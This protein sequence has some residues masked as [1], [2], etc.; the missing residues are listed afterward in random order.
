MSTEGAPAIAFMPLWPDTP[1]SADLLGFEDIA[2]PVIQA[3][4]RPRLDPVAI[5]VH[6]DWGCG[7][8][9]ILEI[10]GDALDK[11]DGVLVIRTRPWEYDPTIDSRATLIG[12]VLEALAAHASRDATLT[13][14]LKDK[15][16][17]LRKRIQWTK[18]ITLAS[19]S[20]MTMTL[21]SIDGLIG[22]FGEPEAAADPTMQGFRTEFESLMKEE[23][24][25]IKRV[26]VLVDDLDRCLPETV[27][28][29]LE[30]IKL[31]LSVE[32]MAFVVAADLRLVRLA[33]AQRFD[34]SRAGTQMAKEYVE[35]IIQIPIDVPALG[36]GDTEAYLALLL[37]D[38]RSEEV[39]AARET[40]IADVKAHC[41]ARRRTAQQRPLADLPQALTTAHQPDLRL[42]ELLSRLLA[43]PLKGN[44]RR[45]KRFLNAFWVRSDVAARRGI[46][47]DGSAL[48]KLMVLEYIDDDAFKLLMNWSAV[49]SVQDNL[50]KLEA[51]E[52][53]AGA[54]STMK[55]W[56]VVRPHLSAMDVAPYL[57]LAASLTRRASGLN[58]LRADLAEILGDLTDADDGRRAIAI[59]TMKK[60]PA[61]D[62]VALTKEIFEVLRAQPD[63]GENVGDVLVAI[64]VEMPFAQEHVVLGAETLDPTRIDGS[65]AVALGEAKA[66]KDRVRKL[67]TGWKDSGV[68]PDAAVVFV[69]AALDQ[70]N[71]PAA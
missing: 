14:A 62:Q 52:A 44:P 71:G 64:L 58:E 37:L 13:G 11:T 38:H 50:G 32:K 40:A 18:A 24:Q 48:A 1:T 8:S 46:K 65:V 59:Q 28:A 34:G 70:L 68:L 30:A 51:N 57:R 7:K 43:E 25:D 4:Q 22:L 9:T 6:G 69:D 31:F 55:N 16:S 3:V 20:A 61:E 41:V 49:G 47:L 39:D 12:E 35:K 60:Y 42:A 53:V 19:K 56:A 26:V 23:L 33:I 15:F 54:P 21:P 29:T 67:L 17:A 36:L 45:L 5:G 2:A 66:F 27:V 63:A 10:V